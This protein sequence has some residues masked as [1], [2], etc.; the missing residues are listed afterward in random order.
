[1]HS[2]DT[3]LIRKLVETAVIIGIASALFFGLHGRLLK[4]A[5]WTHLPRLAFGPVRVLLRYS[6][7][8]VA[9]ILILS[10]WGFQLD[11]FI[12]VLGT[13]LGLVAIGFV[14]VWSVLSNFMCTFILIIFKPFSV[15]DEVEI[16]SDNVKGRVVDLNL[17]FTILQVSRGETI[18]IPNNTFFQR[19]F[20][21]R[22]GTVAIDLH[23]QLSQDMPHD[24]QNGAH[25]EE[26]LPVAANQ[27]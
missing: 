4:F 22:I 23:Y 9:A 21:R 16:P 14:A 1:M 26:S 5:Q 19:I 27:R 15:G 2:L 12:T 25:S 6:L 17:V 10:R 24:G 13:V 8:I 11:T 20:K 3:D 18:M 7:L